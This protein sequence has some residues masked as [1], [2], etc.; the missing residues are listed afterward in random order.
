M[1]M[2]DIAVDIFFITSGF[3]VTASLLTRQSIIEFI[4]ARCLRIFPALLIML[5]LTVFGLGVFFTTLPVQSYI[6]APEIYYYLVKCATLITGVADTLPGVFHDNPYK[7]SV[8]GSLWVLPYQIR[9]YAILAIIWVAL[10]IKKSIRLRTFELAIVTGAFVAGV[11][12]MTYYFY[13]IADSTFLSLFFMFFSGAAFYVLKEHI[14]LSR[15]L[16][17]LFLITLLLSAIANKHAFFFVYALT[18]VYVVFYIAY[19]P[20]GRLRKY[21]L[22]GDYSYGVFIYAFPVQQTVAA[23]VPGISVFSMLLISA[24][25]TL[26]LGV[27][28][29]HL[30]ERRALNLKKVLLRPN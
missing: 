20:S 7:N 25:V 21:N 18:I 29:W 12:V 4:S 14:I 15:S 8:N 1:T 6:T 9:M 16:F 11:L 19:I 23:L 26:F 30:I 10:G 2:G 28:S 24:S 5:V 17:W 27:L 22:V 13:L 3:L